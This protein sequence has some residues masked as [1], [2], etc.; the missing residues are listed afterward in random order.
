MVADECRFVD[1]QT[2][3][4]Q[5]APEQVPTGE[6]PRHILLTVDRALAGRAVPGTRLVAI[7]IY[8]V[9]NSMGK[10]TKEKQENKKKHKREMEEV[11]WLY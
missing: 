1:Q 11:K 7:G 10:G 9:M 5:E 6:M 3:K 2:L 4:L 8:T